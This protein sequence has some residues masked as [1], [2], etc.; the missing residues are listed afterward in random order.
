MRKN[1]S[2]VLVLFF[3]STNIFAQVEDFQFESPKKYPNEKI[4]A[5]F[6]LQGIMDN[7]QA[8]FIQTNI[9]DNEGI[10]RFSFLSR[11]NQE[12]YCMTECLG[13]IDEDKLKELINQEIENYNKE[14]AESN[15]LREFYLKLYSINDMPE[16]IDTGDRKADVIKFKEN[17]EI[18]KSE[19]AEEYKKIRTIN[20]DIFIQ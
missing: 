12:Y 9:V 5:Y 1:F 13:D 18:W 7:H 6:H 15:N 4:I 16:Y 14:I 10:E 3:I 20:I 17:F 11:K 8:F 19:H 2:I